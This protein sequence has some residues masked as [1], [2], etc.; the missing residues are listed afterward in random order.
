[1]YISL[2][3]IS[4]YLT[5]ERWDGLTSIASLVWISPVSNF[6]DDIFGE[7]FALEFNKFNNESGSFQRIIPNQA[8]FFLFEQKV[9]TLFVVQEAEVKEIK[10]FLGVQ[11]EFC[12]S[13]IN[14]IFCLHW[15]NRHSICP[16]FGP[17]TVWQ[18]YY[19]S[20]VKIKI[21]TETFKDIWIS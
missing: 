19:R 1:M 11:S 20:N 13:F 14:S 2:K 17:R 7:M 3:K 10:T 18:V 6:P 9:S 4:N 15:W 12:S 8:H 5:L 16:F 21:H